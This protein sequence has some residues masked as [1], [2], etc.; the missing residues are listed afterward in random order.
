MIWREFGVLLFLA[1]HA[2]AQIHVSPHGNDSN[3]GTLTR[4]LRTLQKA[5]DLARTRNRRMTADLRIYLEPGT[6]RL[7]EPFVLDTRDS[8]SGGHSII[9]QSA[10]SG[11]L[12]VISGGVPLTGWKLVDRA[13]NLWS[14]P[15]PGGLKNARQ[16]YIDGVRAGRT[17]GRLP[18]SV[19]PSDTGYK[20]SSDA[21]ARWRNPADLE[22]V[23]TGGNSIWSE[24]EVGLGGWTE[25]RCPVAAINGDSITMAQPCWD[26]ST[27]RILLGPGQRTANLVGP[28]SVG[29]RPAYVENAYELLG[30]PGSFTSTGRPAPFTTCRGA[31]KT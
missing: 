8:G 15:A 10:H 2:I 5:R 7:T 19:T 25:P 28:A 30:T 21:M 29:N 18:V 14:A 13:R 23:Y 24:R 22:F 1:S 3:P 12:A 6:Y 26:N 17:R 9:Y 4:P 11:D 31:G 27:K 16:I 20:A